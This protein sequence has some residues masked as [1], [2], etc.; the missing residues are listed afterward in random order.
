MEITKNV[1]A[2]FGIGGVVVLQCAAWASG[3]NGQ[4]FA[5]T[6]SIITLLVGGIFGFTV[7]IKKGGNNGV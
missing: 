1:V 3:H 7:G 5:F 6:T 4:V 2:V